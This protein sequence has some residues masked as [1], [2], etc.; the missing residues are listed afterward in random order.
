MVLTNH[1]PIRINHHKKKTDS[2]IETSNVKI[3]IPTIEQLLLTI[4]RGGAEDKKI[5]AMV[6]D[7]DSHLVINMVGVNRIM[8]LVMVDRV[9]L[10]VIIEMMVGFKTMIKRGTTITMATTLPGD[11]IAMIIILKTWPLHLLRTLWRRIKIIQA[12]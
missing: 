8:N 11:M 3:E 6:I 9:N 2:T 4:A 12:I 7:Q 1:N 10:E 5:G